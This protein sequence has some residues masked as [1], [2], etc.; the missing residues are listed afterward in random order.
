MK[1]LI[2]TIQEVLTEEGKKVGTLYHFTRLSNLLSMMDEEQQKSHGLLP[3]DVMSANGHFSTTRNYSLST[4]VH[5]LVKGDFSIHKGY[6]SRITLDGDKI[7]ENHKFRPLLGYFDNYPNIFDIKRN[8]YRV[9]RHSHENEE[10]VLSKHFNIKPYIKRV[11]IIAVNHETIHN[12]ENYLKPLLDKHGISSGISRK[13]SNT[14]PNE[15]NDFKKLNE[16]YEVIY[17]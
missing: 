14:F 1:T 11:D 16:N 9:S 5:Q 8:N 3:F 10:V 7:S 6:D 15:Y 12:Y 2:E 4:D 13:W 17:E